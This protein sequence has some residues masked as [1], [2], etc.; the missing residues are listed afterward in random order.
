MIGSSAVEEKDISFTDA[1]I[2]AS[3]KLDQGPSVQTNLI[4]ISNF[5][6]ATDQVVGVALIYYT[7]TLPQFELSPKNKKL[8]RILIHL[9][10]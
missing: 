6:S 5:M 7:G 2:F 10:L 8:Y 3:K 4:E 9:L 1:R